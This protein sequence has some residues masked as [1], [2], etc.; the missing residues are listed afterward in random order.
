M[1]KELAAGLERVPGAEAANLFDTELIERI[2]QRLRDSVV[3]GGLLNQGNLDK[4]KT[5]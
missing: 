5:G 4:P 2:P 3:G 1:G